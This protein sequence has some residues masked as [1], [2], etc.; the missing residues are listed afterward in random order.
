M[1]SSYTSKVGLF[2]ELYNPCCLLQRLLDYSVV[3]V[4]Q[5]S[6]INTRFFGQIHKIVTMRSKI[7]PLI[8]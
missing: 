7:L 3:K 6:R 4:L 5:K 1:E 8:I 2:P